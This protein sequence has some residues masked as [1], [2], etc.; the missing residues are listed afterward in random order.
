M[1]SLQTRTL[2]GCQT[3]TERATSAQC[4]CKGAT[5]TVATFC[6][7]LLS[8]RECTLEMIETLL[9]KLAYLLER[10]RFVLIEVVG[11]EFEIPMLSAFQ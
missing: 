5:K 8:V 4:S 6:T 2:A 3:V 1:W 7:A 10:V 11:F 9:D